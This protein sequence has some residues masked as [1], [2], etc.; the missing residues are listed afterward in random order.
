MNTYNTN[1]ENQTCTCLD[2]KETRQ[3]FKL[4]DPRRLCK[5]IINKLDI[6]N[7]PTELKYFIE[8]LEYY[9]KNQKSFT[10]DF[11]NVKY[12]LEVD[13]K[14]LYRK[15]DWINVYDKN[16]NKY[17]FLPY[18]YDAGFKWAENKKPKK[19]QEIEIYFDKGE[20]LPAIDWFEDEKISILNILS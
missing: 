9:Q 3:E 4:N 19:F 15:D 5:H 16:G 14:I 18:S 7:L 20:Y 10:K 17:G 13:C 2:W 11:D 12:I 1:L 6:N 8:S